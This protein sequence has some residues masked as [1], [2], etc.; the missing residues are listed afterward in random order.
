MFSFPVLIIDVNCGL[1][2]NPG[3]CQTGNA[4]GTYNKGCNHRTKFSCN[5]GE[6]VKKAPKLYS[7]Q[8]HSS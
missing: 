7:R 5:L 1:I 8:L 4:K 2:V 3:I 6:T